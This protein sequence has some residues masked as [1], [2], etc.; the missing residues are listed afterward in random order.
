[1]FI[2]Y[3]LLEI[4]DWNINTDQKSKP[5]SHLLQKLAFLTLVVKDR[6]VCVQTE[7]EG[8]TL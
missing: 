4:R 2:L 7:R 1:M 6:V 3:L 5:R 8:D